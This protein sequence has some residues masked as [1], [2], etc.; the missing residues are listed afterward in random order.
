MHELIADYVDQAVRYD[1]IPM[2]TSALER[3]LAHVD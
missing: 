1:E 2:L 3:Y